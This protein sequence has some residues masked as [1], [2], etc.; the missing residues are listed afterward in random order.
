[1]NEQNAQTQKKLYNKMRSM[2]SKSSAATFCGSATKQN[3]I[4]TSLNIKVKNISF[5]PAIFMQAIDIARSRIRIVTK[6]K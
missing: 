6:T 5:K 3:V 2:P 4:F 1:M